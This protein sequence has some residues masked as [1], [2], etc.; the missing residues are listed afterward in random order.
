[1]RSS[2]SARARGRAS[3]GGKCSL[4][5]SHSLRQSLLLTLTEWGDRF[6]ETEGIAILTMLVSR[7]KIE[8]KPEAQFEGETF[9]QRKERI[10]KAN[11]GI[12][13]S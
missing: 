11:H 8:L 2:P 4:P 7:Y 3:V 1:M 13:L 6:F 12:T 10:L 5:V 9:E